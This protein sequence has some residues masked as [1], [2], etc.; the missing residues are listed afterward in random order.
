M[1]YLLKQL[2]FNFQK[3]FTFVSITSSS[4]KIIYLFCHNLEFKFCCQSCDV[5]FPPKTVKIEKQKKK[6]IFWDTEF[7]HPEKFQFKRIKNAKVVPRLQLLASYGLSVKSRLWVPNLAPKLMHNFTAIFHIANYLG[8][9]WH[10]RLIPELRVPSDLTGRWF[11]P[12]K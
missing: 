10:N 1:L 2:S 3:F 7:Y 9:H 4:F 11:K 8:S 5:I 12:L 6:R